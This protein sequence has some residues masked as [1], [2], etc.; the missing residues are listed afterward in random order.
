M[1]DR[2]QFCRALGAAAGLV[3]VAASGCSGS[4]D[5]STSGRELSSASGALVGR[6]FEVRRD[7]G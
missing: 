1:L 5:P 7:P 2:R 3:V 4:S 6:R